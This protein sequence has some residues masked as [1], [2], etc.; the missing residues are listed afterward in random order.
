MDLS[1]IIPAR[2]EIFLQRT[3]EDV[4]A[5]ARANTE[6][7]AILDGYWPAPSIDDH[8]N[9]TLIHYTKP[10]GQRAATNAGAR[11][12]QAKYIMKLDAHCALDVGFDVKLIQGCEP[13]WTLVPI[14]YNLH[15]FD[16]QCD[17][18]Y[19]RTYQGN[20]PE[21]CEMCKAPYPNFS[22]VMVWAPRMRRKTYSWRFDKNLQFQYWR[23]HR[24][25]PE[26]RRGEYIETMSLIGACFFMSRERYWE[27]EGLDENHGSWGQVGTEIACKSWLSGGKL[28]TS[29]RTWFAHMFRT[30]NFSRKGSPW[31]YK[32]TSA[33]IQKA[34]E[35]SRDYWLNNK[36]HKQIYPLE[37]L[38]EKFKPV[39]DW[40]DGEEKCSDLMSEEDKH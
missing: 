7:I 26:T 29:K 9:V 23:A 40:H 1:V 32:I 15:A 2:N 36:W 37:W 21:F 38:V 35:Y 10:V 4:L 11:L 5:N 19:N 30:G 31:P 6:V 12:S 18:C 25:R 17:N 16:W 27:L 28:L 14:M 8:P 3:I 13:D 24:K 39:P 20:E 22:M 33:E 34:R